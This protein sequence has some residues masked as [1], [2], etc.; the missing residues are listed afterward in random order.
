M[1]DNILSDSNS[2]YTSGQLHTLISE[3]NKITHK[4]LDMST[5]LCTSQHK[6][7][8]ISYLD[9]PYA[10]KWKLYCCLSG[11]LWIV[12]RRPHSCCNILMSSWF[13]LPKIQNLMGNETTMGEEQLSQYSRGST[14]PPWFSH[15]G[16]HI[17]QL[18]AFSSQ[19]FYPM[20]PSL[21]KKNLY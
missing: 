2:V 14:L 8:K 7:W 4:N 11:K 19:S 12:C 20:L 3:I 5:L 1:G 9:L 16:H 15:E 18:F 13:N 10:S 17:W 6:S 21:L